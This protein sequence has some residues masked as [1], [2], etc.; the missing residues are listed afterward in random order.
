VL[1]Y[2][3]YQIILGH[4]G[5]VPRVS[6]RQ[7]WAVRLNGAKQRFSTTE[8]FHAHY[9][10]KGLIRCLPR[11]RR[12]QSTGARTQRVLT[13][14][15]FHVGY[16]RFLDTDGAEN[17]YIW[18][19]KQSNMHLACALCQKL[20]PLTSRQSPLGY[21]TTIIEVSSKLR[22]RRSSLTQKRATPLTH[23]QSNH[24]HDIIYRHRRRMCCSSF[25]LG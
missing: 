23:G 17:R 1:W 6:L 15:H 19:S 7:A 10:Q 8:Q 24:K 11:N 21:R 14:S 25:L 5:S 12:I 20:S 18:R 9:V 4:F 22:A 13:G 3:R 16:H 2:R